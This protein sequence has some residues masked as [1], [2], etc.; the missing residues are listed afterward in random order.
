MSVP[1]TCSDKGTAYRQSIERE[2]RFRQ[3]ANIV[4]LPDGAV[5]VDEVVGQYSKLQDEFIAVYVNGPSTDENLGR[6]LAITNRVLDLLDG[7][8]PLKPED[9][10]LQIGRAFFL[11]NYA[12]VARDLGRAGESALALNEAQLMFQALV[13][14]HP[15]D[16]NPWNGL[17]SVL[18]LK[19]HP[20][21]ALVYV[22]KSVDLAPDN[23]YA[24]RDLETLKRALGELPLAGK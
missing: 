7:V 8:L 11:K 3:S 24:L 13:K 21:E 2:K 12:M 6:A 19:G 1:V 18:M 22:Q 23:P 9:L 5:P 15:E 4:S 20:Q 17:G 10:Q 14:Q 16:T